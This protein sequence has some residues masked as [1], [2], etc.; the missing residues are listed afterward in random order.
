[1]P[2]RICVLGDLA[3]DYYL[4]LP[5]RDRVTGGAADE[6]IT[7]EYAV[8]LP[9]GTGANAAVAA[10]LLGSEVSLYSAVGD[11]PQGRWLTDAVAARGVCADGVRAFR[12]TSTHATIV[13]DGR[14][15]QVIVDRGVADCLDTLAPP[16]TRG[17]DIVYLTGSG[18]AVRR[19]ADAGLAGHLIAGIEA[20]MAGTP[21]LADALRN[22]NLVITNTAGRAAFTG[23]LP[24][25][26]TVI[27][28]KGADGV[29]LHPPHGPAEQVPAVAAH[30]V[31]TTGAGDCFAGALCHYLLTGLDLRAAVRLAVAAAALST[32]AL[33]AQSALPTDAEVRAA[34]GTDAASVIGEVR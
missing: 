28:T 16:P 6:K 18:A 23:Q 7:A 30:T 32:R 11:D 4:R 5:R 20:G 25:G 3:V 26:V 22:V 31:D 27:E 21:G 34:A 8:R 1:M 14:T 10:C 9:G 19:M 29:T 33:G 15:R 17:T 13:Q 12:G 2:G 24:G